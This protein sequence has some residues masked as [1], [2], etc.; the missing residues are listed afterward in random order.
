MNKAIKVFVIGAVLLVSTHALAEGGHGG[1]HGGDH[2]GGQMGNSGGAQM[3][4]YGG[5][6]GQSEGRQDALHRADRSLERGNPGL[7]R[8]GAAAGSHGSEGRARAL[9]NQK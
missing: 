6:Q 4:G 5:A 2:G 9:G 7:D 3:G 8:A 1:G